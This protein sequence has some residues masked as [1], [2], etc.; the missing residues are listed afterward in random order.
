M[1]NFLGRRGGSASGS[2]REHRTHF[3]VPPVAEQVGN[4]VH[5]TVGRS[6]LLIELEKC[7]MVTNTRFIVRQKCRYRAN[8]YGYENSALLVEFW[9]NV[10]D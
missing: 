2:R 3:H 7:L 10:T 4:R 6:L 8:A 9:E 1:L 5:C